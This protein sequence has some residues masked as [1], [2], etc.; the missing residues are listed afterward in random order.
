MNAAD[1]QS[2]KLDPALHS[3]REAVVMTGVNVCAGM[4]ISPIDLINIEQFSRRVISLAEFR[5]MLHGYLRSKMDLVAPNL[6][7]LIGEQVRH[8]KS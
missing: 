5:Q 7:T 2:S 3:N 8:F 6:S 4:D 1:G